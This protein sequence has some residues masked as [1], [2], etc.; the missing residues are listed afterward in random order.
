MNPSILRFFISLIAVLIV[1]ASAY[2]L[3]P[4]APHGAY[5]PQNPALP[6]PYQV[7]EVSFGDT[8]GIPRLSERFLIPCLHGVVLFRSKS[9]P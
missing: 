5:R 6:L 9:A 7:H 3:W 2:F 1:A 4:R 8:P